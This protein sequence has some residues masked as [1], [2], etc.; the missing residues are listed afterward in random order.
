MSDAQKLGL[1]IGR[2]ARMV[3]KNL[4]IVG[5]G[6]AIAAVVLRQ[7]GIQTAPALRTDN[8]PRIIK[9]SNDQ[10][11]YCKISGEYTVFPDPSRPVLWKVEF[12][13]PTISKSYA[14]YP[15]IG[16]AVVNFTCSILNRLL[17]FLIGTAAIRRL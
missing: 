7:T 5:A 2:S 3:D 10:K 8:G 6:I 12:S 9:V 17:T 1:L 4:K 13:G 14:F 11:F 16:S 15:P